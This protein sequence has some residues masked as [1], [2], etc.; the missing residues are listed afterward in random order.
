MRPVNL[1]GARRLRGWRLYVRS[2]VQRRVVQRLRGGLWGQR[3]QLRGMP[4]QHV[5]NRGRERVVRRV[6]GGVHVWSARGVVHLCAPRWARCPSAW[7][8]HL[9]RGVVRERECD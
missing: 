6:P 2:G 5:L 4:V 9:Q 7:L 1:L 8:P 3:G